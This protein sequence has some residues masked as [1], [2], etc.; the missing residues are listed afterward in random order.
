[1]GK[2]FVITDLHGCYSLWE[3]IKNNISKDD[4]LYCLG[5]NIDRGGRGFEIYQEMKHRPNTTILKGNHE[6]LASRAIPFL[7][8]DG[9]QFGN[10]YVN[11]WFSNGGMETWFNIENLSDKELLTLV[12]EFRRLP[13]IKYYKNKK[14]HLI[15]LSHCGFTPE[16]EYEELWDRKHFLHNW[17]KNHENE[18]IIHGH[19]P[20]AY[21]KYYLDSNNLNKIKKPPLFSEPIIYAGGHKIDLD[22]GSFASNKIALY[23]LD[24]ET[25]QIFTGE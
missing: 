2:N 19:T 6:D 14:N 9:V 4:N 24:N 22:L 7:L 3:Q 13:T 18:Y 12:Y 8:K 15:I 1:M 10:K 25:Y 16:Q 17:P 11:S 20:V 5:D 21:L 23:D